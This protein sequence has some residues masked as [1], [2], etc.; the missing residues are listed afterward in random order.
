MAEF[1][2]IGFGFDWDRARQGPTNEQYRYCSIHP[3]KRLIQ[4]KT[5]TTLLQC[6]ECGSEF[7][8]PDKDEWNPNG[9]SDS[10][11]FEQIKEKFKKQQT[12]IIQGNKRKKK[13]IADDGN[14]VLDDDLKGYHVLKYETT[15]EATKEDKG[16]RQIKVVRKI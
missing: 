15:G 10:Q 8:N 6:P 7:P 14:E 3:Y 9:E 11:T 12:K 1:N 16:K 2:I 4:S 13:Q 5:D